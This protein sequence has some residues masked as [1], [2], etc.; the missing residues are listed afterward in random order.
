MKNHSTV[1]C[2]ALDD[3]STWCLTVS[4]HKADFISKG[5]FKDNENIGLNALTYSVMM[6]VFFV[7][8]PR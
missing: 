2:L 7:F 3:D 6:I 4:R 8:F 1:T 5:D